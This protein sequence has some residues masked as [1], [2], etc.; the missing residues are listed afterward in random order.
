MN[1]EQDFEALIDRLENYLDGMGAGQ[2]TSEKVSTLASGGFA[3]ALM[4]FKF[5]GQ[6]G[7][8][9]DLVKRADAVMSRIEFICNID[10]KEGT[11]Q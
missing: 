10:M 5:A 7:D 2:I 8:E 3:L 11:M 9:H 4:T 6:N 1:A